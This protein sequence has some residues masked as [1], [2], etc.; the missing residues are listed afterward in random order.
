MKENKYKYLVKNTGFLAISSFSSRILVF[1]LV[2]FYTSILST[3]EYGIFDLASTTAQLLMPI[4]T[5][6]IYEGVTRFLMQEENDPKS[7]ISV[8]M[9]YI[10]I[11]SVLFAFFIY[12]TLYTS[13]LSFFRKMLIITKNKLRI[14]FV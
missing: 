6:N 8:G 13:I 11:G 3:S 5:L 2:P 4:L 12:V 10:T 7:I 9:K 1:L 14:T